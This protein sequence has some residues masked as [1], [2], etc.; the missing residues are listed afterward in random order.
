MLAGHGES[1]P[2]KVLGS[3]NGAINH[4]RFLLE[5]TDLSFVPDPAMPSGVR[6]DVQVDIAGELW[7]QVAKLSD[8]RGSEAHY[9]V[10]PSEDG[11]VWIE[12]GDGRNGR[13]LPTGGNNV[14]VRYRQGVGAG[15]NLPPG[16]LLKPVH[17]SPL[18]AALRQ[19]MAAS[20]GGERESVEDLRENAAAA[21]LAL[22][23][24]VSLSDFAALTRGNA[25]VAQ[26]SAFRLAT[27]R[28]Q[29]EKVEVVVVPAGGGSFTPALKTSLEAFL[30]AHSL[31]GVQV[32]VSA[33]QP[34]ALRLR[35]TLRVR[36]EAFDGEA[37]KAALRL[38]VAAAFA[39]ER[40]KLGQVLYRGEVYAVVDAVAGVENSDVELL[41]DAAT[42]AAARRVARDAD[43]GVLSVHPQARQCAH[44]V[45][46][47]SIE[48][49]VEGFT[50]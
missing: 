23:R 38:A 5:L 1:K 18:V 10:R 20:G 30:L 13:R 29:R 42:A 47:N 39:L 2:L 41:V 25:G 44:L 8:S 48:I 32:L 3:G 16:S 4:Q 50:L 6:A 46:A 7:T 36:L 43:G 26:A 34:L 45:D 14:T 37:V 19:P 15:G 27:G 40:R 9:Q 28:S 11:S 12:F 35:L 24:A 33:Y 21:L 22:E 49:A 31:P 17:A